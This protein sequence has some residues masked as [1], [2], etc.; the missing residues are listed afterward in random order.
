MFLPESPR[1]L[2]TRNRREEATNI[3]AR[4]HGKGN[5]Q[6]EWVKLQV[7]E[8][9]QFLEMDGTDKTWWDYRALFRNRASIYRLSCNCIVSLFG[10][11]AGNSKLCIQ[12]SIY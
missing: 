11:W 8:Y 12:V 7:A 9:E 3:L 1:W 6:S 10:Q 2:F 4:F 5:L